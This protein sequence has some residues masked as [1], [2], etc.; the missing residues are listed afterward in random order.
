MRLALGIAM[1]LG[2]VPASLA[3]SWA[4]YHKDEW[5]VFCTSIWLVCATWALVITG[6]FQIGA[7][8]KRR[9]G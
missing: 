9:R 7:W 2:A 6:I 8:V 4:M 3:A 5:W 1:I